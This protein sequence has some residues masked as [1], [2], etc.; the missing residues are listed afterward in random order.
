MML[1]SEGNSGSMC[2]RIY[3][4]LMKQTSGNFV[5]DEGQP[6][7]RVS[8][9][10]WRQGQVRSLRGMHCSC[11]NG[12]NIG[13]SMSDR[14]DWGRSRLHG[15]NQGGDLILHRDVLLK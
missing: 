5:L 11:N 7:A 12:G 10:A 14:G 3:E 13:G 4:A 15:C 2:C 1:G 8:G 6:L 9:W